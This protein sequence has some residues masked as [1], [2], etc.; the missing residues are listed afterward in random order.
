MAKSEHNELKAGIFTL[1]ALGAGV[2]VLVWLGVTDFLL[3][4]RSRA[5]FYVKESDGSTGLS[6]GAL[7]LLNDCE[8]GKIVEIRA[9]PD[10]QRR[11]YV[12]RIDERGVEIRADGRARVASGMLGAKGLVITDR[13][14][15]DAPL[16]D[17]E[18]PVEIG[19]GLDRAMDD[20]AETTDKLNR[21]ATKV[22]SVIGRELDKDHA[23]AVLG[24]IHAVLDNI[25]LTSA[26]AV[27]V[28]TN[29]EEMSADAKPKVDKALTS[30]VNMTASM[31]KYTS[32]D[33]PAILADLR[34]TNT[35]LVTIVGNIRVLT[36]KA[37]DVI[38]LNSDHIDEMILNF[39]MMSANL[40]AA[41][42]EIRRNPWRL[43]D[44]PS[45]R[46]TRSQDIYDASRAFS[47]GAAQLDD[48]LTRLMALQK[49]RPQGVVAGDPQLAKILEHLK[50]SFEKFRTVED[51][52][53]KELK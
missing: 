30:V 53:W 6:E 10:E 20:L 45:A 49:A 40:N 4:A 50:N 19:G 15:A 46:Q 33:I 23:T 34:K 12:A 28:A 29:V 42:K 37:K 41:A 18:H 8:I 3:P 11:L 22:E 47:E 2:A 27:T 1:I 38:V 17:E 44:K 31:E 32:N 39:K 26:K 16:A 14:S 43:L 21:A 36:A 51:T 5:F 35:E 52:L 13:G 7:L 24:K 9:Q 48:A 25:V